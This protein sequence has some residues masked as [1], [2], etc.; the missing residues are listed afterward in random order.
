MFSKVKMCVGECGCWKAACPTEGERAVHD[1]AARLST[2]SLAHSH[3]A[4][5]LDK[6]QIRPRSPCKTVLLH[7]PP[8]L[9]QPSFF[10][11]AESE[12]DVLGEILLTKGGIAF[13]GVRHDFRHMLR[14]PLLQRSET[15]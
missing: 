15:S 5:G 11:V 13:L 12:A 3:P 2:C 4:P 8:V 6:L 9:A 7:K 14:A 1:K 10:P